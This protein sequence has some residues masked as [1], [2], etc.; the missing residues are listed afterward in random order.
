MAPLP[1][2]RV[3][4]AP[5]FAIVGIDHTGVLFPCDLPGKFYVL[6]FTCAAVRAVH[7]ELVDSLT[8]KDTLLA[9]RRLAAT[10][11]VVIYSAAYLLVC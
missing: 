4:P 2:F 11:G 6:L 7:L 3:K 8:V 9:L 1:E 10:H 5:P